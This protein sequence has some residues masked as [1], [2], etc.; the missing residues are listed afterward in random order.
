M[1]TKKTEIIFT[2]NSPFY[3]VNGQNVT[4]ENGNVLKVK[5][6][7]AFC[8]CG[9]SKSMPYCDNKHEVEGL[10]TEKSHDRAKNKWKSYVGDN[11]TVHFNLGLCSHVA[12]C[13]KLLPEVFNLDEKP[14]INVNGA[15]V[16]EVI[17]VVSKCPS[18]ALTYT[19]NE[20]HIVD[21][22]TDI[23]IKVISDGPL[24]VQGDV[25]LIDD[26]ESI[27][28]L[29]SLKRYTLCRCGKSKNQPFCDGAHISRED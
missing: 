8:R 20:K 16:E 23:A 4:D 11:I 27:Q 28:E 18:G 17:D 5:A 15:S 12:L 29:K 7:S 26:Q 22:D 9:K 2:N 13:L 10:H 3:L 1:N 24:A 25:E 21:F 6:V 19:K 14:W